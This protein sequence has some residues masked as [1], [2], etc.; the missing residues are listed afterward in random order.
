ML[1]G[2]SHWITDISNPTRLSE[3]LD[4]ILRQNG[5]LNYLVFY[6]DI[7]VKEMNGRENWRY[8]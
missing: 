1:A 7:G 5:K 4:Q 8:L 6:S 2:V 3:T